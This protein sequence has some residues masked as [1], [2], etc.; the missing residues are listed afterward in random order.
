[1][2]RRTIST[3]AGSSYTLF[4]IAD[5]AAGTNWYR[6]SGNHQIVNNN[7]SINTYR[8]RFKQSGGAPGTFVLTFITALR[9]TLQPLP[10]GTNM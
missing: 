3:D 2:F 6:M 8:I 1:M 9:A 7:A 5:N 4:D 10:V